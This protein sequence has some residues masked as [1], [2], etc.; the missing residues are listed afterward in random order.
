MVRLAT[1]S[2]Y[3]TFVQ[4]CTPKADIVVGDARLK[5]AELERGALDV[6][7]ID[8]FSSDTVPMHLLTREAFQL[9]ARALQPEGTLLVHI[10][11]RYLDLEPVLA[12]AARHG[13]WEAA[14]LNYRP[15]DDAMDFATA[16][17]WVAMSKSDDALDHMMVASGSNGY[18]RDLE[19]RP[20]FAGWS[21][22]YATILPLIEGW[23]E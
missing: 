5:I 14:L 21:D 22:D 20:G 7:A 17:V 18:W 8:A 6:L 13:G 4:N 23:T 19:A 11:N 16:S 9:Y 12:A 2:G 3:F 10:S 15:P 1:Q